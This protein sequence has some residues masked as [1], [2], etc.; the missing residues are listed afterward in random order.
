MIVMFAALSFTDIILCKKKHLVKYQR[1]VNVRVG[2]VWMKIRCM[3]T[4]VELQQ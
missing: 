1:N 4:Y 3:A 2:L